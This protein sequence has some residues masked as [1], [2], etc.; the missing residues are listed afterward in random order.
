[1]LTFSF[2]TAPANWLS[3][4]FYCNYGAK[5]TV[6]NEEKRSYYVRGAVDA[7]L[8]ANTEETWG[9]AIVTKPV[10]VQD[11]H[12]WLKNNPDAFIAALPEKAL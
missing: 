7:W 9:K 4:G 8:E 5:V 10:S 3:R 2:A 11:M 1:M 12:N 6:N